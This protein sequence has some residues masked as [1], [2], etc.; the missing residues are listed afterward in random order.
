MHLLKN[1][2]TIFVVILAFASCVPPGKLFEAEVANLTLITK[3]DSL[4]MAHKDTVAIFSK[5]VIAYADQVKHLNDS[6]SYYRK[7]ALKPVELTKG[8][9]LFNKILTT[10]LLTESDL[11]KITSTLDLGKTDTNQWIEALKSS[12]KTITGSASDLKMNKGFVYIDVSTKLLFNSGKNTLSPKANL[13]L[14]Q[15]AKLLNGNPDMEVMVE[16]HTDNKLFKSNTK[17]DNW[18]L[19]VQRATSVVRILQA[20]HKVN[21]KRIIAAGRSEYMPIDDN[22]TAEGRANNR[23]IRIV[24]LPTLGQILSN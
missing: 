19:S 2:Y 9:M 23:Y 6:F 7:I 8:D 3:Y 10:G 11:N 15:I 12:V 21:P 24:L 5:S 18:N 16:G 20:K 13:T 17:S 1:I 14:I 22:K 4:Y